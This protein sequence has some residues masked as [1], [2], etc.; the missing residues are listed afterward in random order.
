MEPFSTKNT[1][2]GVERDGL[3]SIKNTKNR[4]EQNVDGMIWSRTNNDDTI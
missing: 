3:L 1:K 2:N 4:T